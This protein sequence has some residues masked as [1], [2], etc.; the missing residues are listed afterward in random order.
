MFHSCVI[1]AINAASWT[2][3]CYEC[4]HIFEEDVAGPES[5]KI[6]ALTCPSCRVIQ[7]VAYQEGLSYSGPMVEA[8]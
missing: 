1:I 6:V 5:H 4:E 3:R 7:G 2:V 8:Q